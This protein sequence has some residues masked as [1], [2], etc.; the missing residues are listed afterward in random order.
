MEANGLNIPRQKRGTVDARAPHLMLWPTTVSTMTSCQPSVTE[1]LYGPGIIAHDGRDISFVDL[2]KKVGA[3]YN[4][5]PTFCVFLS[6]YIANFMNK[7]Y[8]TGAFDLRE[9]DQHNKIEHD[10]SLIRTSTASDNCSSD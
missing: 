6:K 1:H 2:A 7:D 10:G 4:M 8:S 5:A 3:T 9:L